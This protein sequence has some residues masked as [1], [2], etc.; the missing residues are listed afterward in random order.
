M[1]WKL[2]VDPDTYPRLFPGIGAC[3]PVETI[4]GPP[5][6]RMRVGTADTEIRVLDLRLVLNREAHTVELQCPAQGSFAAARLRGGPEGTHVVITCF[7]PARV[8]PLVASLS[9]SAVV[10]WIKAGLKRMI[11]LAD[12]APTSVLVNGEESSIRLQ[13][14]VAKQ[15][16]TTGVVRTY[17][18]DRIFRQL[19]NLSAWGFTLA[20]GYAAAAAH[21]PRRTA[22]IDDRGERTFRQ[23]HTR[24]HALASAMGEL[25]LGA[26]DSIGVLSRNHAEMVE[27]MSAA[28]KLGVDAILFNLGQPAGRIAEIAETTG[29]AMLFTDPD[30]EHLLEYLSPDLPCY[31]TVDDGMLP[32]R[33]TV[34]NLIASGTGNFT[35]PREHGRLIVLTSG[36][37]GRAKGAVRPHPKGFGT[38]AAVLSRIPLRMNETMLIPAPVFHTWGLAALQISTPLRATVILPEHFDAQECLRMIAEFRVSTLIVVPVMVHRILDLP[39]SILARYDTSSLRIVAS[40]GAPLPGATVLRFMDV[41]GEV[42]Y[43]FYGSTEVSWAS[44]ADPADLRSSPTTAGRAPLGTKIAVLD[45]DRRPV[46]I[47]ATG[48]IFISNHMLFDGY[49]DADPPPEA[50]GMLDTGDLGYLDASGRLFVA[51]RDDEMIISGGENI[52]P[53]P[54]EEVLSHLPQIRE[55]AV[56]GVADREFGQR[57]AAFI[58]TRDGHALDPDM[59]R[60]HIRRRLGR[61]SVPR[62][63][64]FVDALP[65][66]ATG[67]VLKRVLTQPA[68]TDR[69]RHGAYE[70][71][72]NRRGGN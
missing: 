17:R 16:L 28:S 24:S 65:R 31:H 32:G 62:D 49:T 72:R 46:P 48:R 64:V 22:I 6:W 8:H 33:I 39:A 52:F 35:K 11:D 25:G 13:A 36:T 10:E 45:E 7:A 43:N 29:I 44:I 5:S 34:E 21:S 14:G 2:L 12:R 4:D 59:L 47:G 55:V 66:N 41:F 54:V 20:G 53:R 69:V 50:E 1:L 23:V 9:N 42:L 26:G 40:C 60:T 58:V 18:P 68:A 63:I 56:L 15:M 3:D 51:G 30:L 70:Y 37:S 61:F 71:Q 27:I 67:K 19:S 57:L 38:V